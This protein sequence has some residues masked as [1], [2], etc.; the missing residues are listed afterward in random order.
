MLLTKV[1]KYRKI[2]HYMEIE[3]KNSFI[4]TI[5]QMVDIYEDEIENLIKIATKYTYKKDEY[6]STPEK[7]SKE[8]AFIAKGIF[9]FY[10]YDMNGNEATLGFIPENTFMSSYSAVLFDLLQ[11][12]YIQTIENSEIYTVS[13][14]GFID[15][16]ENNHKWK[17]LLQKITEIDCL[18][19]RKRE[20][21]FLQCDAKTRY[22]NFLNE[23]KQYEDRIKI[24]HISSYLGMLPET[25]SRIRSEKISS[26]KQKNDLDH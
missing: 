4:N 21:E 25:L 12:V 9:R 11:P 1:K 19:L 18:R 17:D 20:V 3:T 2:R 8:L 10:I 7:V 5:Q 16:C 15:I 6:F 24:K 14:S 13:R 23:Y 22:L 26:K